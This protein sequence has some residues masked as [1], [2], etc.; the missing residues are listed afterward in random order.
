MRFIFRIVK[1]NELW[2]VVEYIE[3]DAL[4][5]IIENTSLEEDQISS[6]CFEVRARV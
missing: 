3:G 1:N 5:D 6:I 2:V 4:T